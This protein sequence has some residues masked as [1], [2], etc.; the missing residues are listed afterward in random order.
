ME[1]LVR[2]L[3]PKTFQTISRSVGLPYDDM[4]YR[5]YSPLTHVF[6]IIIIDQFA[7][8]GQR[9]IRD[10]K[11]V[12]K[13]ELKEE[14]T[15]LRWVFKFPFLHLEST[16]KASSGDAFFGLD[17]LIMVGLNTYIVKSPKL[18]NYLKEGST[19]EPSEKAYKALRGEKITLHLTLWDRSVVS[20]V[21]LFCCCCYCCCKMLT[22]VSQTGQTARGVVGS[23]IELRG[24]IYTR[25][26]QRRGTLRFS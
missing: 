12:S 22:Y 20:E 26:S 8:S 24:S 21:I 25:R 3:L 15:D 18:N 11:R 9:V 7:T 5:R 14:W 16:S 1:R 6:V 13:I 2:S 10:G 23:R 19:G 17:Q 4:S